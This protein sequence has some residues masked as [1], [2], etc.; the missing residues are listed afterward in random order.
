[1]KRVF[2]K[3]APE[4]AVAMLTVL[5]QRHPGRLAAL[6]T[7]VL[8]EIGD[9]PEVQVRLVPET[10]GGDRCSV[11]G[12]YDDNTVPPTLR[13]GESRSLRRRGFTALHEL[14][15]H[16]QQTDPSLGEKLFAWADSEG[17]EE[18]AC[19]AFA[20]RILLPE[21][22]LSESLK[23]VG[24]TAS[25]VVG[26]FRTS[27]ASREACCVRASGFFVGC[28]AVVLLDAQ[29]TVVFAARHGMIPPACGSDQSATPLIRAALKSHAGA[30]ADRTH[31]VFRDGHRSDDLYGQA[32]WLDEDYLVAVFGPDQVAW[33]QFT[34]PRP[35]SGTSR[36]LSGWNCET[37]GDGFAVTETCAQCQQPRCPEG[38]CGCTAA[39]AASDPT[40]TKCFLKKGKAQFSAGSTV[41]KECLE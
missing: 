33:R 12:S 7:D 28:G 22:Q 37:C 2:S 38:H 14:G 13:V 27:Q 21:S 16:L 23:N 31:F 36:F 19:D 8:T 29:G 24:P 26:L 9:W 10:G 39:R 32:K 5:E 30:Q 35:S 4:Q 6:R 1:M 18:E 3:A 40:C 34:A 11:A 41:C 25:D 17:L 15:H 20:A